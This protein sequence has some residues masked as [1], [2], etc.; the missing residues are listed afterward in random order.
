MEGVLL[1]SALFNSSNVKSYRVFFNPFDIAVNGETPSD[2]QEG[3]EIVHPYEKA[4]ATWW[5]EYD[6]SRKTFETYRKRIKSGP[7]K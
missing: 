3:A 2:P 4:G 5:I 6:A 7:P 1:F